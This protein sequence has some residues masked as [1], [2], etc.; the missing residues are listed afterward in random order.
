MARP[1]RTSLFLFRR[2][3]RLDDNT[4]LLEALELSERVLPAF[5]FDPRQQPD[6]NDY[7]SPPAFQFL[8]ESLADLDRQL[9]N[10]GGLLHRFRGL[11]HEVIDRLAAEHGDALGLDAVFLNRDYTPFSRRRDARIQELCAGRGLCFHPCSDLLLHEPGE[12]RTGT[13]GSYRVFTPFYKAA[14]QREIPETRGLVCASFFSGDLGSVLGPG[15]DD[16]LLSNTGGPRDGLHVQGGRS[17]ALG[18]LDR[19]GDFRDYPAKR[20]LPTEDGTTSL[21]AH[22]KFGT[23]SVREVVAA[24]RD[25][26]GSDA[27]PLIRQLHWRDFFTQLAWFEPR[28]FGGAF[29]PDL[30]AV[31]WDEGD[32]ADARFDAWC[33]GETGFP[34]VDAGMRQ[35]AASG[36]MHN[37]VR[38]IV[39]SFLTKDLH[40]D[41]RRGERWFARHLLDYDPC[42]NNGNWQWAASTGADAQPWFRIFNPWSQQEKLDPE[43]EYIRRWVPEL[44]SVEP[45][46]LHR[47]HQNRPAGLDG[48]PQPIVDHQ[49][50]R[51]EALA[52][53]RALRG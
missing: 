50:E 32:E 19:L 27:E 11:P 4:G 51:E 38:M 39:A 14:Q 26:L 44:D 30:D 47:L 18:I 24:L 13:G 37:R 5:V 8:V 25:A 7:F 49:E 48:Y 1:Y 43:G 45:R 42:V 35:L 9:A 2:D 41:W 40:I 36:W 12:V 17:R 52:R 6:A 34:L 16:E 28:V 31:E 23:V 33:R 20:D 29:Q 10:H 22:L 53:F 21:S 3:L 15:L 46:D